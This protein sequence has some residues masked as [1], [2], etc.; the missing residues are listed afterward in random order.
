MLTVTVNDRPLDVAAIVER[1]RVMLP[2]RA[3]FAALGAAVAYDP[4]G[5]VIVA[6]SP[7]HELHLTLGAHDATVDGHNVPLDVPARVVAA[8]IY[9]PLRLVAQAMGAVVGYDAHANIVNIVAAVAAPATPAPD[10]DVNPIPL[11]SIAPGLP[12]R[13]APNVYDYRFYAS[14][15]AVYY[16][17]DLMHFTLIAPPGGTAQLQL[18]GLGLQY[19]LWN[20]GTGTV[21]Q[22]DVPAPG[23]YWIPSCTV[24]AVYTAWNGSQYYVPMPVV[25]GIFTRPHRA[26][27]TPSPTPKPTPTPRPIPMPTEPRRVPPSPPPS[28]PVPASQSTPRPAPPQPPPPTAR[29]NPPH[30]IPPHPVPRRT[31]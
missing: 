8:R 13:G 28:T 5:R 18:C 6:R 23:G 7:V 4:R 19:P 16:A 29:P 12:D 10:S 20:A 27:P 31:P 17:G 15:P 9:I 14:G 2:M 1:G 26:R 30:P 22:A 25:V 21:Y 11:P 24:T 3:T